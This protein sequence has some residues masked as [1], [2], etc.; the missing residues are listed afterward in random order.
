VTAETRFLDLPDGRL[1]YDDQGD[2]PLII[3]TPAML[4]LRS[5]LRFLVPRLVARGFRV[6][7]IDQRGMGE[8]SARWPEYG[9]TPMAHDL[10]ALIRHLDAGPALIYGTSNG[11]AAGVYLA[12]EA[13][14]LVRGLVLAAPFVRDGKGSWLQRQLMQVMRIPSLALPIY[15]S[16]FPKWEPRRPRVADFD[17]H[18]ARL[19]A[20]L[21]EPGR[22]GV[23]DAYIRQQ[24]HREAEARIGRVTVPSLV[25]MGTGD[26]DWPDPLAEADWIV[27]RL[28]SELLL[29]DG[30]GHHPH[31]E[32]PEEVAAAVVD[33]ARRLTA[34]T[35]LGHPA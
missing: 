13:P 17:D 29:L 35:V 21:G 1:A 28:G 4:D 10:I 33:F 23:I 18:V 12:A 2:G 7:S 32:C 31:V 9:S 6:V 19:R 34:D 22:R 14:E 15:I 24:S 25:I 8:S 3:A 26:I 5:E 11:A 30:A 16:Y 20:N 27:K